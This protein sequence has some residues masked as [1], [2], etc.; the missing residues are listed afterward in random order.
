MVGTSNVTFMILVPSF[1]MDIH[2]LALLGVD[3]L[4]SHKVDNFF[5]LGIWFPL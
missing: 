1:L 4:L 2:V 5:P 3:F